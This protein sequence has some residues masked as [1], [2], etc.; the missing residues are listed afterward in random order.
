MELKH[1]MIDKDGIT[2][3]NGEPT[4]NQMGILIEVLS[5]EIQT[6][7]DDCWVWY[8]DKIQK[9]HIDMDLGEVFPVRA[10]SEPYYWGIPVFDFSEFVHYSNS[11]S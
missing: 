5:E 4:P 9:Y 11:F 3:P 10:Q 7:N 1:I 2:S 8:R 6:L